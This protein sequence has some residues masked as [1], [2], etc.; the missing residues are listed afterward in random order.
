MPRRQHPL[1]TK[2]LVPKLVLIPLL[3][4]ALVSGNAA[5]GSR[6]RVTVHLRAGTFPDE[7]TYAF[8]RIWVLSHRGPGIT[9]IKPATNRAKFLYLQTNQC[10]LPVAGARRVWFA[11]CSGEVPTPLI[12]ALDPKTGTVVARTRGTGVAFGDGSVWTVRGYGKVLV[13]LDPQTRVVLARIQLPITPDENGQHPGTYGLGALW[14]TNSSDAVVRV[15]PA[16][17]RVAR[18]IPLPGGQA[19]PAAGYFD[20]GRIAFAAGKV[21][22]PNAGGL[23]EIDPTTNK[24]TRLS[25]ALHGFSE[26]GDVEAVG[27]GDHV[28]VRTSDTSIVEIDATTGQAFRRFKASGGGGGFTVARGSLW[29]ANAA[30]DTVWREPIP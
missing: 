24:A 23:Y 8:G 6:S 13:R 11:N 10:Y 18:V 21:W 26:L 25:I 12:Y 1:R 16:T 15:D 14:L 2:W 4:L 27:S 20:T 22:V 19:T 17:N 29:I 30:D 3:T 9:R 7:M 5:A 28:F